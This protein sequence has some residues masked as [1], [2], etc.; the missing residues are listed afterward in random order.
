MPR[1]ADIYK[2]EITGRLQKQFGYSN[3]MQVPRIQKIVINIGVGEAKVDY[4]FME[5]SISEEIGIKEH[6]NH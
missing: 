6:T 3:I 4:K 2:S 1:L 5:N